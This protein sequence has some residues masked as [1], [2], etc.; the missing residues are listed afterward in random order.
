MGGAG[1]LITIGC[2]GAGDGKFPA[3]SANPFVE[4]L[5]F[6]ALGRGFD[7]GDLVVVGEAAS[8]I[9]VVA[10][11][12][13][14][15]GLADGMAGVLSEDAGICL[16]ATRLGVACDSEGVL[17]TAAGGVRGLV[18]PGLGPF[19]RLGTL[20]CKLGGITWL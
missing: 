14:D 9:L 4:A 13:M 18:D 8:M 17:L 5:R 10:G 3:S 15:R 12:G 11:V 1:V 7:L 16:L 6:V 19:A 2:S 20:E